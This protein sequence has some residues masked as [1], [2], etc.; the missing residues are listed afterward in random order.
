MGRY[1]HLGKCRNGSIGCFKC[2]QEGHFMKECPKNRQDG[3]GSHLYAITSHREQDDSPDVV[4]GMI[5]VFNFNVLPE[6]LLEP[7]CVSTP[8]DCRTRVVK[9]QFPSEP[10]IEWKSNSVVPKG[11]F[12]SY[13]KA[14]KMA[15]AELK[16]L[17]K[18]LKDLLEKGF[19]RPSISPWGA[20]VSFVRKKDGSLR[21]CIDYRQ[22]NKITIKNKY[23]LLRID[24]LFDQLQGPSCFSKM[25]LRSGY[26]KL[27]VS[28][29]DIPKTTFRTR[30]GHYEFLVMSFG[31]TNAPTVFMDLMNRVFKPYL[32][33][34]VI[35]FIDDI[36]IYSRN[37]EDHVS[38]LRIVLQT[39]KDKELYAKFSKCEFWM[40]SVALLG[41]IISGDGIRI[42]TQKIEAVQNWP[43]PMSPIGIRSFLGLACYYRSFPK[44]RKRLTTAPILT[45][46]EGTQGF[47]V[48]CDAS[49]VGLGCVL[50]Q[51]GKVI[52]YASTQLKV[53]EKNY[54]THDLELAAVV[55][56]LKIWCHYIYGVHVDVFTDHKSLQYVFSQKELNLRQR[57]LCMGSIAHFEE[58]KKKLAKEVYRLARLG[59]RLMD[60]TKG[61]VVVMNGAESSLVSEVKEKQDQDPL[62]LE[63]KASVHRQMAFEQG[64]DDVLSY[65]ASRW[66]FTKL[67]MG[68]DADIL[69]K[70]VMRYGKKGKLSP[71]YIGPY[72][73]S[74]RIGN[75]AYELDLPQELA[76]VHPVFHISMLK[77]C[78]GLSWVQLE[79]VNPKPFSTHSARESEWTKAEVVLHCCLL[80]LERNQFDSSV[81]LGSKRRRCRGVG[82]P[83][84]VQAIGGETIHE[85]WPRF[86]ALLQ[87]C[88]THGIPDKLLLE[89]FYRGLGPENRSIVDQLFA[90]C[91][92]QQPYEVVAQ[93]LDG[94]IKAKKE[95]EKDQEWTTLL[96]QLDV[97]SKKVMELE[98]RSKKKDKYLPPHRC[99][100]KKHQEG[101]AGLNSRGWVESRHVGSFGELGRAHRTTRRFTEG[102]HLAFNFMI[103]LMLGSLTFGEKPEFAKALGDWSKVFLIVICL[104]PYSLNCTVTFGGIAL[105]RRKLSP[106]LQMALPIADLLKL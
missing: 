93:L 92:I 74:K 76:V 98:A 33:M 50:M 51:N 64:R 37:N 42:D 6:Q 28:E 14:R 91:L 15:P 72:R 97:L 36:L 5:Q 62:L 48:Y 46:P 80:V 101:V 25:D 61:G 16:E 60:S 9:F 3:E 29:C 40:E 96:T 10:V 59:V 18:Q 22:L 30:Y 19:I 1:T 78:I 84:N 70:G 73:I 65:Q 4:T 69:L 55:F 54:P 47:V 49:R 94:M 67:F 90:G 12:I 34:F 102:P 43:R 56:V 23:P 26:H 27:K 81:P 95:I 52:A 11:R 39:L 89:C 100:K 45:L 85:M 53:H 99:Q 57:R 32:D 88:P 68:E 21:M 87:Q 63:L 83:P 17:K 35:V 105:A 44:L 13:L 2:G 66:L 71:W 20:P 103:Y 86:K 104:H 8:V 24:D 75:V 79:R 106:I 82:Y 38:H 31:L 41:H 7:F 77:K 58:D